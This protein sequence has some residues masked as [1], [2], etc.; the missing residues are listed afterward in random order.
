MKEEKNDLTNEQ[1]DQVS[2][3]EINIVE[4]TKETKVD[5]AEEELLTGS[6]RWYYRH[7]GTNY[8]ICK[9][10]DGIVIS[11]PGGSTSYGRGYSVSDVKRRHGLGGVSPYRSTS[12]NSRC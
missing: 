10:S 2:N 1:I 3:D 9:D 8:R 4:Y 7:R 5:E 6:R 11:Y 12:S